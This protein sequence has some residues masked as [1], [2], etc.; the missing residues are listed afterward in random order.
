MDRLKKTLNEID[1]RG[2][3]TYDYILGEYDF[4]EFTLEVVHVQGDP[5]AAPSKITIFLP[6]KIQTMFLKN[7]N[8][9]IAFADYLSRR[10]KEGIR[11]FAKLNRGS[12][13][14]G[15]I[16]I[17]GGEQVVLER[18]ACEIDEKGIVFRIFI[19]DDALLPRISGISDKPFKKAV[20]FKSPSSLKVTF[21]LPGG[22]EITVIGN[23][24]LVL[25]QIPHN[26]PKFPPNDVV[27]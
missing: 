24:F 20:P 6:K 15:L 18:S 13:S 22:K 14:S 7:K 12:G 19:A 16:L 10:F 1:K 11:R 8:R 17:D 27:K 25:L 21:F 26:F 4:R 5:F 2:Y 9:R 3:K 23:S